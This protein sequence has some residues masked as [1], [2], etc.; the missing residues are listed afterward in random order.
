[1]PSAGHGGDEQ[2][3]RQLNEECLKAHDMGDVA[4]LDRI[5][6]A[7]FTISGDFGVVGKQQQLDRV[8]QRTS[9]PEVITRK[10]DAQQFRFYDGVALV[11]ETDRPTTAD[12][13]FAFQSTQVWVRRRFLEAGASPLLAGGA[14]AVGARLEFTDWKTNPLSEG[15]LVSNHFLLSAMLF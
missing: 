15:R 3:I 11:T 9:K 13:T 12:G 10:T 4:T 2:T 7:D 1:M 14:K 5:E 6:D 8:R